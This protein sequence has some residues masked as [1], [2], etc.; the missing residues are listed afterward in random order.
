[1]EES[2]DRSLAEPE[3]PADPIVQSAVEDAPDIAP[4]PTDDVDAA[5]A[6]LEKLLGGQNIERCIELVEKGLLLEKV[7]Q[8][9]VGS[10][11]SVKANSQDTE[12]KHWQIKAKTAGAHA[13]Y[14]D[15]DTLAAALTPPEQ[16]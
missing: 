10:E 3:A 2:P 14:F 4:D 1:M 6:K 7:E 5:I 8:L 11:I 13:T 9:P 16:A 12:K 15:G